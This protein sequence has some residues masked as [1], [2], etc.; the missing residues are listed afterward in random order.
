RINLASSRNVPQS[1]GLIQTGGDDGPTVRTEHS[2]YDICTMPQCWRDR[3]TRCDVPYPCGPVGACAYHQATVAAE[4]NVVHFALMKPALNKPG[5]LLQQHRN[6]G[7]LYLLCA[8][9]RFAALERLY[10][11]K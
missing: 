3:L 2:A 8:G 9:I 7:T 6:A 4:L 1:C 5:M 11:P 10:Q